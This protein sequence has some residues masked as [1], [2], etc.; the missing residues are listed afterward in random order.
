MIDVPC[1]EKEPPTFFPDLPAPPNFVN[2]DSGDPK[3]STGIGI[4]RAAAYPGEHTG[5]KVKHNEILPYTSSS[6]LDY[7]HTDG[8]VYSITF[9]RLADGRG[10]IH[11]FNIVKPDTTT[12]T[13]DWANAISKPGFPGFS[14]TVPTKRALDHHAAA[15][16]TSSSPP[17]SR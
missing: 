2:Y 15:N 8:N 12:L 10:W 13:R 4:R 11:D 16:S 6:M 9:Y 3:T 5:D 1:C 7:T 17:S 14:T